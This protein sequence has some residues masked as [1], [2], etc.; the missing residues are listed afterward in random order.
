ML[1]VEYTL[2]NCKPVQ[3]IDRQHFEDTMILVIQW[4]AYRY[5]SWRIAQIVPRANRVILKT[6]LTT[7]GAT[8]YP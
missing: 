1:P 7:T 3:W 2:M 4:L 8:F 6:I 5:T